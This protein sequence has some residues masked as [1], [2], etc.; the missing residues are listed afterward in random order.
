MQSINLEKEPSNSFLVII[1]INLQ[2]KFKSCIRK[3]K[4]MNH[5]YFSNKRLLPNKKKQ[6]Y[7]IK[8]T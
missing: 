8:I 6:S 7:C 3:V 5:H 4:W 1:E 2:Q